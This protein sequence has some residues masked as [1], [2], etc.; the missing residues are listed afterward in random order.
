M[1]SLARKWPFSV[2]DYYSDRIINNCGGSR[3]HMALFR[4]YQYQFEP[5]LNIAGGEVD[6]LSYTVRVEWYFDGGINRDS[7]IFFEV[8]EVDDVGYRKYSKEHHRPFP[9]RID[10]Y[11]PSGMEDF[12]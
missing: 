10:S 2:E 7:T 4:H 1:T 3:F 11:W 5:D 8:A 9:F 12:C 6:N